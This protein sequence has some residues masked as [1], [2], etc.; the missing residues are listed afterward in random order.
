MSEHAD[1]DYHVRRAD[2]ER[3]LA[4]A[5]TDP[6]ITALHLDLAARHEKLVMPP[7]PQ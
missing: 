6:R 3:R 5:S 4:Q 2:E 7:L 1:R